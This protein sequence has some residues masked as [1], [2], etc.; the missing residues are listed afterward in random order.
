MGAIEE[1]ETFYRAGRFDAVIIGIGYRHLPYRR[2][3][4][5]K[6]S[7]RMPFATL[8][9]PSCQIDSTARIGDGSVLLPGC[10]LDKGVTVEENTLLNTG[11]T[12]AHDT[13]VGENCF[14]GPGVTLAGFVTIDSGCF[15]GVGTVVIDGIRICR[16]VQTG[17]GAV[18][19]KDIDEPGLYVGVPAAKTRSRMPDQLGNGC[20]GSVRA[21]SFAQP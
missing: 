21:Q 17:G 8:V 1:A 19:I 18:L 20:T 14:L 2:A 12:V 9:H 3:C 16:N 6:F 13:K 15:L 5:Q 10:V 4:F 11:C 7:D